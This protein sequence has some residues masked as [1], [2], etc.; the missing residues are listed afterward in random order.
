VDGTTRDLD[1]ILAELRASSAEH[2]AWVAAAEALHDA[3][4]AG[5]AAVVVSAG[6]INLAAHDGTELPCVC[7]RCLRPE[8]AVATVDGV[9][10]HREFATQRNRV[11]FFWLPADLLPERD[12]VRRSVALAMRQRIEARRP[13]GRAAK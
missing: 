5:D 3:G 9:R 1:A 4:R 12:A 10:F 11:L 13:Y 2:A 6:L 7:K 8:H